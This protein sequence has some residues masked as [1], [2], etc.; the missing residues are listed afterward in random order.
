MRISDWSSDVCSSDLE[1]LPFRRLVSGARARLVQRLVVPVDQLVA[2]VADAV[3]REGVVYR[4]LV[5]PIAMVGHLRPVVGGASLEDRAQAA[6]L[7]VGRHRQAGIVE[8]GRR[9]VDR[10]EENTSELQSLMR[11]S[12]A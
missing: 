2:P 4:V 5:H 6:P 10:S 8:E 3:V 12:Y 1:Q 7:H 11:I 9:E